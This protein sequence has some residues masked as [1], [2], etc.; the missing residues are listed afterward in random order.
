M[1]KSKS[2]LDD[3]CCR[4]GKVYNCY[5]SP[6]VKNDLWG[7]LLSLA[8]VKEDFDDRGRWVP[9]YLCP[10]CMETLLER[11]LTED[12]LL[13]NDV[14]RHVI[15]NTKFVKARF[16]NHKYDLEQDYVDA[17]VAELKKQMGINQ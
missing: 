8:H 7:H 11:R 1:K 13:L 12:D 10:E 6:M 3:T 17:A 9:K 14:N 4:C 2:V 15:W 5:E 16:P